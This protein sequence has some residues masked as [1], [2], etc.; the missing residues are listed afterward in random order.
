M[1]PGVAR[2]SIHRKSI[3][4]CCLPETYGE[5][6][7]P[8]E[9]GAIAEKLEKIAVRLESIRTLSDFDRLSREAEEISA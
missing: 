5:K 4:A 7:D 1:P 3:H 9:P 8:H 6:D 2:K